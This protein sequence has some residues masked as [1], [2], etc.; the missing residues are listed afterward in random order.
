MDKKGGG[1]SATQRQT[2]KKVLNYIG[3]YRILLVLSTL[4]AL[5]SVVLTLYIPKL[6]GQSVDYM[7]GRGEVNFD[8]V[9]HII[10]VILIGVLITGICQ[11]LMNVINNKY[12][13]S[14]IVRSIMN[15]SF[16]NNLQ[17]IILQA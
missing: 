13:W 3:K 5:I 16:F 10:A 15:Q 12:P 6:T 2:V 8:G 1:L 4:L 9:K 17:Q 14:M 7:I 11:W